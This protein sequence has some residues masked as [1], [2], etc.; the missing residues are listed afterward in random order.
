MASRSLHRSQ[1]MGAL[2]EPGPE[3]TAVGWVA[4]GAGR[5]GKD[6]FAGID[7]RLSAIAA[8]V[9]DPAR[10]AEIEK[11]LDRGLRPDGRGACGG[12]RRRTSPRRVPVAGG[13][14]RRAARRAR[15]SSAPGDG[16]T[17]MLLDEK[18][19]LAEGAL[20]AAAGVTLDAL[21]EREVTA[22]GESVGGHGERL[23]RG[24]RSRSASRASRSCR[25]RAGPPAAADAGRAGRAGKLE[26][27]K[28]AVAVPA[29]R[30]PTL[31]YFLV[32]AAR[33]ATSTTGAR[34]PAAVRGEP[35]APAPADGARPA[36]DRRRDGRTLERDVGFPAARRGDRRDPPPGARRSRAST[37]RSS[38]ACWSGRSAQRGKRIDGHA[39]VER[40]RAALG[41]CSR[42]RLRAGWPAPS[43]RRRSRSR[44][45]ATARSSTCPVAAAAGPRRRALSRSRSP[46]FSTA[47]ARMRPRDPHHRLRVHP[48]HARSRARRT[49][50][51][52]RSTSASR[53]R[54]RRLR[55]RR[56]RPRARGAPRAS[57]CRSRS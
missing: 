35:F 15:R 49:S 3:T 9:P 25:P 7:T 44:K 51:S 57:A 11:H 30:P 17:A 34:L 32:H 56:R 29:E 43:P 37:S 21:A 19:A 6:L 13:G 5:E 45:A 52:R 8:E 40:R 36:D 53:A 50:R 2:Q 28:T 33:S 22:P 24:R 41:P 54:A 18:I 4:G 10:R 23:E 47:D 55:A 1:D 39:D 46:P 48:A 12:S 14:P 27:W 38:R 20:A 42:S 16:G 26:E 31:P